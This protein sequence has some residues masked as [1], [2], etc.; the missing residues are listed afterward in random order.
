MSQEKFAEIDQRLESLEVAMTDYRS[1]QA[2]NT[3]SITTLQSMTSELL[4]IAQLHQ[5]AL[6]L[7]QQRE[8]EDRAAMREMQT[9]IRNIQAETRDIQAEIRGVW[10]YLLGQQGNGNGGGGDN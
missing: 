6:R 3:A 8:Q 4:S 9:E 2:E 10:Q 7:S 1:Q 5:Q